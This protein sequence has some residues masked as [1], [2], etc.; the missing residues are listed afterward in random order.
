MRLTLIISICCGFI[1]N[2][3]YGQEVKKEPVI[4]I[5]INNIQEQVTLLIPAD[6]SLLSDEITVLKGGTGFGKDAIKKTYYPKDLK[7]YVLE[8][9]RIFESEILPSEYE[10][11]KVFL[12]KIMTN[13][14]GVSIYSY[15]YKDYKKPILFMKEKRMVQ[16]D[17]D[18]EPFKSYI[19]DK[20]SSCENLSPKDFRNIQPKESDILNSYKALTNCNGRFLNR[21]AHFGIMAGLNVTQLSSSDI[22]TNNKNE[23]SVG[24]AIGVFADIPFS[25][26]SFSF[27][28]ELFIGRMLRMRFC[29]AENMP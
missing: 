9:G 14:G 2:S 28:P 21:K 27:R 15:L 3:L 8:D 4:I 6:V 11:K 20:A 13:D 12:E 23:T 7:G 29:I 22:Y 16:L 1:L 24:P 18:A 19:I 10:Y 17:A 5:N 25:Y 26:K